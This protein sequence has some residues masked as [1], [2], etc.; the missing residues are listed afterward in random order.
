MDWHWLTTREWAAVLWLAA[1]VV[2]GALT[3]SIRQAMVS[4]LR[5]WVGMWQLHVAVAAFLAWA[6]VVC[7]LGSLVGLWT[8]ALLKDT[9]AW[10]GVYGFASVFSANRAAQEE[11]FFRRAAL[12][13]FSVSALMQFVLNLHTF[14]FV[15]EL[16]ILPAV[17]FLVLLE[18]VAGMQ[19]KTRSVQHLVNGLLALLGVW[20]LLATARALLQSGSGL[21]PSATALA[22]AF[23][24]WFPL[25]MLPFV[26]GLSLVLAYDSLLRRSSL[27]RDGDLPPLPVRA[28][29]ILGLRGDVRAVSELPRHHAQY[30]AVCRAQSFGQ[31][32]VAVRAYKSLRDKLRREQAEQEARL[33]RYAGA[34]GRDADGKM[35]D[36]REIKATRDALRRIEFAHLG[37]YDRRGRYRKDLLSRVLLDDFTEHGLP[38]DH[39]ITM[40]VRN[41]GRAW[42]AWRST[43]SGRVLG[44]GMDEGRDSDRG[45]EWLYEGDD[46]PSGYP[47]SDSSWGDTAY[48]TPPNWQ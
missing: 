32:R 22:F 29:M 20:V 26:Y 9:V 16:L 44:I 46:P 17:T 5:A 35:L 45:D 14:N 28:A 48:D 18:A 38:Q 7:V 27:H 42:Y 4:L 31:A 8:V 39:G 25:A 3:P 36:Q 6:A 19:A 11:H 10:V 24:I 47:G 1:L 13:A 30:R 33:V 15:W 37:H 40:R 2:A 43:P 41:D 23:S 12:S 34:K 21:D